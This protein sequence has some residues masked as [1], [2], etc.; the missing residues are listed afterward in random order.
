M[1]LGPISDNQSAGNPNADTPAVAGY[2]FG[3][4]QGLAVFS[5]HVY[6]AWSGDQSGGVNESRTGSIS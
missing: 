3:N 2:T 4:H 6:A 5:G 1:I